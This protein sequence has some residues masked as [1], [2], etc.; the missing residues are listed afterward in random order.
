MSGIAPRSA[1]ATDPAR[2][3]I[4]HRAPVPGPGVE[5]T[6]LH[7]RQTVL[8]SAMG[9]VLWGAQRREASAAVGP[10]RAA[11]VATGLDRGQGRAA[12]APLTR[13]GAAGGVPP[14]RAARRCAV[15]GAAPTACRRARPVGRPHPRDRLS[16]RRRRLGAGW[17]DADRLALLPG[18]AMRWP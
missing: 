13:V 9:A 2:G 12:P 1:M 18:L 7:P 15:P 8:L 16:R 10:A 4:R 11:G 17:D 6:P 5:R 3:R 14:R